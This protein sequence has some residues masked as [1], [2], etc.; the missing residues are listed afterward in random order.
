MER[1][2]RFVKITAFVLLQIPIIGF[3]GNSVI[4]GSGP[5][6]ADRTGSTYG[7]PMLERYVEEPTATPTLTPTK[8]PTVV[9]TEVPIRTPE[10][11]INWDQ[12]NPPEWSGQAEQSSAS[13][14]EGPDLEFANAFF[15]ETNKARQEFGFVPYKQDQSLTRA[16]QKYSEFL[17]PI[18]K[19]DQQINHYLDG[20]PQERALRE[21]Y[22]GGVGE[23]LEAI[24]GIMEMGADVWVDNLLGSPGHREAILSND[25]KDMGVGCAVGLI[26]IDD[27]H[28]DIDFYFRICIQNFGQKYEWDGTPGPDISTP[29]PTLTPTA[30]PTIVPTS[31]PTLELTPSPTAELSLTPTP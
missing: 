11:G 26:I 4:N 18:M 9:S 21:G 20:N 1:P 29:T 30:I 25:Y 19:A 22:E 24:G 5:E 3:A 7:P 23:N 13:Y 16:A 31:T 6:V 28:G 27:P 2:S 10:G 15:A 12:F 17:V 14:Q 8:E